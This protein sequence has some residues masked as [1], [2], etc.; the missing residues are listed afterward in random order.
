MV[1]EIV[2][3]IGLS[4]SGTVYADHSLL[5]KRSGHHGATW[6]R[7]QNGLPTTGTKSMMFDGSGNAYVGFHKGGVYRSA[8]SVP[9][10]LSTFTAEATGPDVQL[11]WTTETERNNRGFTIQRS[12]TSTGTWE[13]MAFTDH[14]F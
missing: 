3:C 10:A 8:L 5:T 6:T 9:V 2:S 12:R 11:A 13:T 1:D 4:V 14:A 7:E